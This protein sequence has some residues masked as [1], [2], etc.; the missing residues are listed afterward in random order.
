MIVLKIIKKKCKDKV[1][2]KYNLKGINC[3]QGLSTLGTFLCGRR[4]PH[5]AV[6]LL[7]VM[8]VV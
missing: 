8:P 7:A 1:S 6:V 5:W 3:I 4:H 2:N